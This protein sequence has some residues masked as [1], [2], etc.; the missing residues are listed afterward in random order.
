MQY[1]SIPLDE[2]THATYEVSG[3][4]VNKQHIARIFT[5]DGSV[6]S[7]D[8]PN[9]KLN[10]SSHGKNYQLSAG[11]L[12]RFTFDGKM[13]CTENEYKHSVVNAQK[14]VQ[15]KAKSEGRRLTSAERNNKDGYVELAMPASQV[16]ID[17]KSLQLHC[18]EKSTLG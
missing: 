14:K 7:I 18:E 16:H 12:N 2:S 13:A 5:N 15:A 4:E 10:V 1:L 9:A 3:A 17:M 11:E 8:G 6:I